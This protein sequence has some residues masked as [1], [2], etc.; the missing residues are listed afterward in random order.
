[1]T[2]PALIA[3]LFPALLAGQIPL[4]ERDLG[5]GHLLVARRDLPDPNFRDSVVFLM[6]YS[7]TGA[8]GLIINHASRLTLAKLL[9]ELATVRERNDPIYRGGPVS[10]E[11]VIALVRAESKP[12]DAM[13]VLKD[14][15]KVT[16]R[17]AL[18]KLLGA[19]K[20]HDKLRLFIGYSGWAPGQLDMEVAAGVWHLFR[21]DPD[22]VFSPTPESLYQHL[23]RRTELRIAF[24]GR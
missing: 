11:G 23:I 10:P 16:S 24:H 7:R 1:M 6:D 17:S 3:V 21:A 12:G 22:S 9:P 19:G 4:P 2:R 20:G 5:P 13:H 8:M 18:E 15:Y 14:V